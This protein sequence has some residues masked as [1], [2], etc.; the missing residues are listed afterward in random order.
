LQLLSLVIFNKNIEVICHHPCVYEILKAI[1]SAFTTKEN[2]PANPTDLSYEVDFNESSGMYSLIIEPNIVLN[3]SFP[4]EFL[5]WFEKE[6]TI[7]L[8]KM[9][10]DLYFLHAA[11]LEYNGYAF[12]LTGPAGSGKSTM[13]WALVNNN[14]GYLSDE[15]APID[16]QTMSVQPYPHALC[17]KA[18]PAVPYTL[19]ADVIT[20]ES[21][22][23][24]PTTNK[25][26]KVITQPRQI[27]AIFFVKH[28]TELVNPSIRKLKKAEAA[29]RL[30]TNTLNAL[31]HDNAG[32]NTA[33]AI[34]SNCECYALMTADLTA[35]CALLKQYLGTEDED[36]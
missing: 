30:Y 7:S 13:T 1:F 35:T 9:R 4:G 27:K 11:A 18:E 8:Q 28:Q 34:V 31:A 20:T 5:Y 14:C 16:I 23:H 24:I 3:T 25:N 36:I 21:A 33:T 10:T 12:I 22:S 26:I 6:I 17:L 2:Q 15:L 32:L 29:L 19:P